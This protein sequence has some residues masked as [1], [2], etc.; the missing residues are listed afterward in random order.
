MK[1]ALITGITGQ[2]GAYLSQLLIEKGYEVYGAFRGTSDLHLNRLKFLGIDKEV[3]YVP[4]ELREF[5]NVS[6]AIEQIQPDEIYNLGAQSSVALSFEQP[7]F[8]VDVTATGPL[9]IIEA[10]RAINPKIRFYQASS[11]EMFGKAKQTPQNE[12][13]PFSPR[14]PYAISKMFAHWMTVSYRE[15][16]GM[17]ACS[18]ILFNH[19]SPLRGYEFVTRKITRAVARIKLG[20]QDEL[21]LG[22]LDAKRD[23]GY[24]KEYVEAMWLMLQQDDPDDYV[25]A[26]GEAHS[27]REFVEAGFRKV[28]I[29]IEWSGE[30]VDA[31]G[32]DC[33]TGKTVVKVNPEF[34]RPAELDIVLGDCTKAKD[35][36]G[37]SPT[38]TFKELVEM[39]VEHDLKF[40]ENEN[41]RVPGK[42]GSSESVK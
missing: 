42:A 33:D 20:L 8:S 22:N 26:T 34:F 21:V 18:G 10:I 30:G 4:F 31:I 5:T 23:W 17:F 32:V 2:D 16:Y 19:E 14:S 41:R 13:T 12:T 9:R 27:V 36:L 6:R 11:S 40:A 7:I 39:M 15:A 37:W 35:K 3:H 1:K 29:D 24:A 38:T 25:I 28:D